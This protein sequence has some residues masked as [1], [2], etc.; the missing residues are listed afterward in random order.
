MQHVDLH[1]AALPAS[2]PL[3]ALSLL[4]LHSVCTR[5]QVTINSLPHPC[6][7][8]PSPPPSAARTQSLPA[9]CR[10]SPALAPPWSPE[11]HIAVAVC[12]FR[13]RPQCRVGVIQVQRALLDRGTPQ[14]SHLRYKEQVI[15]YKQ[16]VSRY[17]QQVTSCR[18]HVSRSRTGAAPQTIHTQNI[19][20]WK[21]CRSSVSCRKLRQYGRWAKRSLQSKSISWFPQPI[22]R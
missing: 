14:Q 21:S 6:I 12:L 18:Q 7:T 15:R 8:S 1:A 10:P 2:H 22:A 11:H 16:Q 4:P 19:L 9:S 13:P 3:H 5:S 20:I 17:E